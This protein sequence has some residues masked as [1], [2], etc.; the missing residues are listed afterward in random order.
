M[1]PYG[2]GSAAAADAGDYTYSG[3][4]LRDIKDGK[5]A[6]STVERVAFTMPVST[7]GKTET[8]TGNVWQNLSIERYARAQRM[9]V[10]PVVVLDDHPAPGLAPVQETPDAGI[11]SVTLEFASAS[12]I[13]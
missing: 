7:A 13:G 2:A 12:S 6:S 8:I 5:I 9:T 1:S 4:A 10:L 3:L 11:S